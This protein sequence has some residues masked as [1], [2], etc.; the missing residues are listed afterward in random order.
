[1]TNQKRGA[2]KLFKQV[3]ERWKPPAGKGDGARPARAPSRPRPARAAEAV[4]EVE[5]PPAPREKQLPGARPIDQCR[6]AFE[7]LR[8][9]ALGQPGSYEQHLAGQT[10]IKLKNKSLVASISRDGGGL[11][12]VCKLPRSG[13]GAVAKYS[14]ASAVGR[15]AAQAGWVVARFERGAP[16]PLR[17]LLGWI[18]ESAAAVR[19]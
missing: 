7:A 17:L 13:A 3:R 10:L 6:A 16:V 1:M 9:A 12:L 4:V 2:S 14:W 8:Q 5:A 15:S 11:T 19:G 18:E